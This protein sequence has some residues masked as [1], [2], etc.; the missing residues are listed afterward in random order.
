MKR[1]FSLCLAVL[2]CFGLVCAVV[3]DAKADDSPVK[4]DGRAV[5]SADDLRVYEVVTFGAYPL[6]S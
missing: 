4:K 5:S 1:F 2:M 6:W 3:Q